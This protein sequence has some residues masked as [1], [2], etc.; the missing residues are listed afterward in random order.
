MVD[1][2]TSSL[3]S[4]IRGGAAVS[5]TR[6]NSTS[7]RANEAPSSPIIQD[8]S[9]NVAEI[10]ERIATTQSQPQAQ[11]ETK[12]SIEAF[13]TASEN[14]GRLVYGYGYNNNPEPQTGSPDSGG[15]DVTV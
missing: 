1:I 12:E 13:R 10:A 11:F 8:V 15:T 5:P 4:P 6:A 9:A 7:V 2:Q 3:V 14:V